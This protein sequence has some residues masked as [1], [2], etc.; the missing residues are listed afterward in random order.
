MRNSIETMKNN[1]RSS[2]TKITDPDA[3]VGSIDAGPRT[4]PGDRSGGRS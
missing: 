4:R 2:A 3:G 1:V